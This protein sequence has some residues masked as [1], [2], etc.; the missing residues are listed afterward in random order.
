MLKWN[1]VVG[2]GVVPSTRF[3]LPSRSSAIAWQAD[4][5]NT[6]TKDIKIR[7]LG[8]NFHGW[9]AGIKLA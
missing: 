1:E 8:G 6:N 2:A 7:A 9:R 3:C 4:N 5:S